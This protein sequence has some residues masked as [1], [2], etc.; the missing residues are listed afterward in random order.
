M[1]SL[2]ILVED[3]TLAWLERIA[4]DRGRN[5][6]AIQLAENAV[7]EAALADAK[8]RGYLNQSFETTIQLPNDFP[9]FLDVATVEGKNL[10]QSFHPVT[11]TKD[12]EVIKDVVAYN[13]AKGEVWQQS[14]DEAGNLKISGN[15]KA[16]QVERKRI[17][18]HFVFTSGRRGVP[19][20]LARWPI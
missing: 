13:V 11:V 18:G 4:K 8:D 12:G 7:E 9:P 19:G 20:G 17:F 15:G 3:R 5:E 1:Q 2:N 16:A 6:T 14:R 10:A